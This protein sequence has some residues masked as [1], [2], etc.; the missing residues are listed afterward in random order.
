MFYL[1]R[2]ENKKLLSIIPRFIELTRKGVSQNLLRNYSS[3]TTQEES[4][5]QFDGEPVKVPA[6]TKVQIQL[7]PRPFYVLTTE[8]KSGKK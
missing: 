6:H 8:L 7:S 1:N 2:F 4:W 3:F 5:A